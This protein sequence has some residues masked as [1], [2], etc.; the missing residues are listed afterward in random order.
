MPGEPARSHWVPPWPGAP[1]F[2]EPAE[3]RQLS[4]TTV[5]TSTRGM[6]HTSLGECMRA[7]HRPTPRA[8]APASGRCRLAVF[9]CRTAMR[10]VLHI[11][12]LERVSWGVG[13]FHVRVLSLL[14]ITR[15]A[16]TRSWLPSPV[17]YAFLLET[18]RLCSCMYDPVD[19]SRWPVFADASS[20]AHSTRFSVRA[21][22]T[23]RKALLGPPRP[24]LPS[25]SSLLRI[26]A[27]DGTGAP[28][29]HRPAV[30]PLYSLT[31]RR[32]PDPRSSPPYPPALPPLPFQA[33]TSAPAAAS[34]DTHLSRP[35][36]PAAAAADARRPRDRPG[37]T[38]PSVN[39]AGVHDSASTGIDFLL[40][41][42]P[43]GGAFI[44]RDSTPP[45]P[46]GLQSDIWD[47]TPDDAVLEAT[48]P[49]LSVDRRDASNPSS[50]ATVLRGE[51]G[52]VEDNIV[53]PR[54]GQSLTRSLG[55]GAGARSGSPPRPLNQ[56]RPDEKHGPGGSLGEGHRGAVARRRDQQDATT[57]L[58]VGAGPAVEQQ[59]QFQSVR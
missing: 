39:I 28:G 52:D 57:H 42:V 32:P 33:P 25:F 9:A 38:Q 2:Y 30:S 17:L 5:M 40:V 59:A 10:S 21:S 13:L 8:P 50:G 53:E 46:G 51:H 24:R 20:Y 36:R 23:R 41:G 4:L 47:D 1:T 34:L 14:A 27:V 31:R 19:T 55:N 16:P 7:G 11:Y 45:P 58:W 35:S 12:V 49:A 6:T 44:F 43:S 56:A 29:L 22:F 18:V 15:A 26:S 37:L 54:S 48:T 3:Q